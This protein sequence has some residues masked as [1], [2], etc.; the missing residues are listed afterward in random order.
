LVED[1]SLILK[2]DSG[3]DAGRARA[4]DDYRRFHVAVPSLFPPANPRRTQERPCVHCGLGPITL[5]Y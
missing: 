3:T 2:S 4:E 5:R 1:Q